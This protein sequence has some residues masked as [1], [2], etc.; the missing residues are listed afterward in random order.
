MVD[1]HQWNLKAWCFDSS[2]F[3]YNSRKKLYHVQMLTFAFLYHPSF[4][5]CFYIKLAQHL[6]LHFQVLRKVF[7]DLS[8]ALS[9][10][11]VSHSRMSQ[12]CSDSVK[13]AIFRHIFTLWH[14]NWISFISHTYFSIR[15]I[16]L[17]VFSNIINMHLC[18]YTQKLKVKNEQFI[19]EITILNKA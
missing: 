2:E 1:I 5:L 10:L 15:F 4:P 7:T 19:V 9:D 16:Y 12:F 3:I 13:V 14:L 8:K 11:W 17:L 6:S 18:I